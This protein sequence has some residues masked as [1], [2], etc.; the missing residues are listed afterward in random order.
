M[1]KC[2]RTITGMLGL[3]VVLFWAVEGRAA[4]QSFEENMKE[5]VKQVIR[6]NPDLIYE[7]LNNYLQEKKR[8]K[9]QE[10]FEAGFKNR[11]TDVA[12]AHN[13][14]RGLENAPIT[15][16]E[17]TDFQCP[18]CTRGSRT[19]N[20]LLETFPEEVKVVFKNLPLKMHDQA[21][22]AAKAAMAA[23]R[24]EKFWEYHDLL[25]ENSSNLKEELFEKLAKDLSLD[26]ERFN[27]DR[28]SDEVARQVESDL[29]QAA[30]HKITAAPTFVVNGVIVMGARP[31]EYFEK[32]IDR[33]L[34]ETEKRGNAHR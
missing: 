13:P 18:Y 6:E 4:D 25:F 1:G 31:F 34:E 16:V 28:A 5:F 30:K 21:M 19:V 26:L 11:V 27:A 2:I 14:T 22:P 24:Q 3:I 9:G 33:L 15:I 8:Q 10:Q 17:Y 20:E 12:A 23:H 29:E 7:V 32:V